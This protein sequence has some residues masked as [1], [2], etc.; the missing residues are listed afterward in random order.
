MNAGID[1]VKMC[2]AHAPTKIENLGQGSTRSGGMSDW[3]IVVT[4]TR[5]PFFLKFVALYREAIGKTL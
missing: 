2:G 3:G 4:L 5:I 1:G